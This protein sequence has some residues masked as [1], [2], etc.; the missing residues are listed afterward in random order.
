LSTGAI[1]VEHTFQGFDQ[2]ARRMDIA[3][4]ID[5]AARPARQALVLSNRNCNSSIDGIQV[6]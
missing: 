6:S 5:Q 2:A 3:P 1:N 4:K